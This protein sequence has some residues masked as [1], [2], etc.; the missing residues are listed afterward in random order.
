EREYVAYFAD[1]VLPHLQ[2]A[3][4][5]MHPELPTAPQRNALCHP[6]TARSNQRL[7]RQLKLGLIITLR[8][9]ELAEVSTSSRLIRNGWLRLLAALQNH[10]RV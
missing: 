2:A 7:L 1:Q 4:L 10:F 9:F 6:A 8:P 5:A 3:L